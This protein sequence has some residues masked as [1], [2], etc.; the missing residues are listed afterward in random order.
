M[1]VVTDMNN[2]SPRF[3][4]LDPTLSNSYRGSVPENEPPGQTVLRIKAVDRDYESPNNEVRPSK[5]KKYMDVHC[6][7]Y[8]MHWPEISFSFKLEI[9]GLKCYLSMTSLVG[10]W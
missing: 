2:E 4:G 9:L 7:I 10:I 5:S 8:L 6:K 3:E 1:I